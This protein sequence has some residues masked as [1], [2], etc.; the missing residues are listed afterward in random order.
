VVSLRRVYN[1]A[2]WGAGGSYT[3]TFDESPVTR[4]ETHPMR[5]LPRP[6]FHDSE[7]TSVS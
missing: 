2:G 1:A 5:R 6:A 7:L 4:P 3:V